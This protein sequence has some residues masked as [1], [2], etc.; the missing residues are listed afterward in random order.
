MSLG[1]D[2]KV[3]TKEDFHQIAKEIEN[4]LQ[5]QLYGG[6]VAAVNEA[7]VSDL[8][9]VLRRHI[10]DDVYGMYEPS[11]D[12]EIKYLRRSEHTGM[13]TSLLESAD[14]KHAKS[15]F[16]LKSGGV[17]VSGISYEPTGEHENMEWSDPD[18]EPD[19][20][21]SRIEN[22][23]PPYNFEHKR[24]IPKRPFWQNFVE[25]MIEGGQFAR[26]VEEILKEK[27]I[28]E[29]GDTIMGVTRDESDGNY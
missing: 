29:P 21:I 15:L 9:E 24:K 18:I 23:V 28:A 22:K 19:R 1:Y 25:E 16:E 2:I 7:V 11:P 27:G 13:G 4:D 26:T 6:A 12:A 3:E 5:R 14:E 10:R 20:L 17:W 8:R